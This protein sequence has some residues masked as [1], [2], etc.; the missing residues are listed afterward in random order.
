MLNTHAGTCLTSWNPVG[1]SV[2]QLR[3]QLPGSKRGLLS[4]SAAS[5]ILADAFW[6]LQF[7]ST[8]QY[9]AAVTLYVKSLAGVPV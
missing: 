3:Q 4:W 8:T 1:S 6:V 9:R 7:S 2:W 5:T